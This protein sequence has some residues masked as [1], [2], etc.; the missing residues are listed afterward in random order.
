MTADNAL[1]IWQSRLRKHGL[2]EVRRLAGARPIEPRARRFIFLRHG[3]TE[4]NAR[5]PFGVLFLFAGD[6]HAID[7]E[8]ARESAVQGL[9]V[10]IR[11]GH[12]VVEPD[13]I[14]FFRGYRVGGEPQ[15]LLVL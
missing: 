13:Y 6:N 1:E 14:A 2:D 5:H 11:H 12:A 4:G 3:E 15:C 8:Y 7:E 10:E 9:A